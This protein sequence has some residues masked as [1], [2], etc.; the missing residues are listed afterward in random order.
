MGHEHCTRINMGHEHCTRINMGHDHCKR[1]N[2]GHEHCTRINMGHEH[3]TRINMGHEHCTRVNTIRWQ[4]HDWNLASASELIGT[5][6]ISKEKAAN[7]MAKDAGE[8]EKLVSNFQVGVGYACLFH[9][10]YVSSHKRFSDAHAGHVVCLCLD[11]NVGGVPILSCTSPHVCS[12]FSHVHIKI[13]LSINLYF[14]DR[15][16]SLFA[17]FQNTCIKHGSAVGCVKAQDDKG[18]DI[19]G[20]D[21][22]ECCAEIT[23]RCTILEIAKPEEEKKGCFVALLG[24]V[25]THA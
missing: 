21:K 23:L 2:M 13:T 6:T 7:I 4:V 9:H 15:N 14:P 11:F 12:S 17:H 5:F 8:E 19:L 16:V 10:Q 1:I 18:A 20:K 3:C 22:I 25:H 24:L